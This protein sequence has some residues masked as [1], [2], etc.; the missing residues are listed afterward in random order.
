MNLLYYVTPD[1]AEK[2]GGNLDLWDDSV[3]EPVT[4][5]STFNRL[6]LIETNP[7]SWHSVSPA[8]RARAAAYRTTTSLNYHPRVM[9]FTMSRHLQ[10]GQSKRPA[11]PSVC[12]TMP[13]ATPRAILGQSGKPTRS[14]TKEIWRTRIDGPGCHRSR[15]VSAFRKR[16]YRRTYRRLSTMSS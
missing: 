1:W 7:R 2:A 12:R 4:I 10:G 14:F 16:R 3:S 8:G 11:A 6:V 5:P 15:T 9:T 13:P